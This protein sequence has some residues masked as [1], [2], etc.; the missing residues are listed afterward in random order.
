ML[1]YQITY[2]LTEV[3]ENTAYLHAQWRRAN[4]KSQNPYVI[5]DGIQGKGRYVGTFLAWTQM[6]KG[7]WGEG[8]IKFYV[9]GD[10]DFPTLCGTG[11]EDY[12]CGSYGFAQSYSTAYVGT[13][14][15]TKDNDPPPNH[16]SLYRW[17]IPDP[18]CFHKDLRVTIQALGWYR[19][20]K[21]KK[22]EDDIASVAYWY[23]TEPHASF[24]TLP[25]A[26]ARRPLFTMLQ[27]KGGGIEGETLEVQ[28]KTRGEAKIQ[29]VGSV[30]SGWSQDAQLWWTGARPGDTL[31]LGFKVTDAGTYNLFAQLTK[32][33]DYGVVQLS[34][35][36]KM[37]VE[38]LDLYHADPIPSGEIDLGQ[39]ALE[40]GKHTLEVKIVG[41]NQ[42]AEK[43]YMFGIDYIRLEKA[44]AIE[45]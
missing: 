5:V 35:D 21:Y 2:Q 34:V 22:L 11:T 23:Q 15:P 19:H 3:P 39:H 13:T 45:H 33:R 24:P 29:Q 26:A 44:D 41:A 42:L 17:H 6:E 20:G 40:A 1:A 36:G 32:A 38:R 7:W 31:T 27:V 14:L 43:A 4:T 12:F 16:W 37:V 10:T 8:E 28:A 30:G 9:D 25:P 18:I